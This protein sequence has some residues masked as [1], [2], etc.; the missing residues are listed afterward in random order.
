MPDEYCLRVGATGDRLTDAAILCIPPL[1]DEANRMRRTLALTMRALAVAGIDS[2]MPDLPGQNES[3]LPTEEAT[4]SLW[5]SA[6]SDWVAAEARPIITA[7]WRGGALL[8]GAAGVTARW[9]MAPMSGASMI[10]TLM[11]ARIATEREAG[12][13]LT[14]AELSA[15]A[16][17]GTV[18]LAGNRLNPQ[19]VAEL[20][21]AT[22]LDAAPLRVVTIGNGADALPGSPLWLRTEPG[23]DAGMAVA[24]AQ[25][26]A[27]WVQTCAAA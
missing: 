7:A 6:L 16:R 20:E 21:G 26:I 3:L 10:R 11:R 25:D 9:R 17:T 14:L 18:E 22:P 19:M 24:M 27:A 2:L 5:R 13:T 8:D 4:L 15:A 1:F 23:V 12:R